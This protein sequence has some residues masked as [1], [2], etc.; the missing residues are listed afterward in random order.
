MKTRQQLEYQEN[1]LTTMKINEVISCAQNLLSDL[2]FDGTTES[3][4]RIWC[5]V[6]LREAI[7][8]LKGK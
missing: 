8:K 2:N 7:K 1:V 3:E 4:H 5:K 6:A